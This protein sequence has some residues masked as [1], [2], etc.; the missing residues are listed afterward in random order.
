MHDDIC[1][2]PSRYVVRLPV[3]SV[4]GHQALRTTRRATHPPTPVLEPRSAN[5]A[6]GPVEFIFQNACCGLGTR[7]EP[8]STTPPPRS[9]ARRTSRA[10]VLPEVDSE[11]EGGGGRRVGGL[12]GPKLPAPSASTYLVVPGGWGDRAAPRACGAERKAERGKV[13]ELYR[14]ETAA[15]F[16]A[17]AR[18]PQRESLKPH[19]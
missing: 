8:A 11:A 13:G 2:R 9:V 3:L 18:T 16:G 5:P 1:A 14:A 6:D 15:E 10:Y 19:K 12:H 17:A 7:A 4:C